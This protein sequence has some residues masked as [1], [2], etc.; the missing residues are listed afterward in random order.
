MGIR[1]HSE[2]IISLAIEKTGLDD[3]GGRTF[4]MGLNALIDSLH[5]DM[6]LHE[7]I[8]AFF[9]HQIEQLLINR[10]EVT[11]LVKNKPDIL[12]EKIEQPLFIVGLPRSGT[13][14]LQTLLSLDPASR[15]LRNFETTGPFCP[16]AELIPESVDTRIQACHEGMKSFFTAAPVLKG[17][18]GINFVSQGPAE[19]QNLMAHEFVHLGWSAGSSLFSHGNWVGDCDMKPAY[20]WHKRLLKVLQWKLPNERWILKAPMHLFGLDILLETYPDAK[21]L[22]THRNA[23]DAM[24]S[25]ISMVYHWTRFTT[26]HAD[27]QAIACWY[28]FLWAKGLK[29]ALSF[30]KDLLPGQCL[31]VFHQ[32]LCDNPVKTVEEIYDFLGIMLSKGAKKRMLT[33]LKDHPRSLYGGHDYNPETYGLNLKKEKERFEFYHDQYDL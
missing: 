12:N 1:L 31:D 7:G 24:T 5:N 6:N 8:A 15:Y 17:I 10:L 3:F 26:G 33:W 22:F 19:C 27:A 28:P 29:N 4:E 30:K 9:H 20:Q 32:E 21:I 2:S 14:L 25:G 11:E 13:T 23:F 18:N 16:P